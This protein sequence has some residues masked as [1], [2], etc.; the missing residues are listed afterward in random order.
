MNFMEG[1]RFSLLHGKR[2]E[3]WLVPEGC[4]QSK[5][6]LDLA[7]SVLSQL[8]HRNSE[9]FKQDRTGIAPHERPEWLIPGS[10]RDSV[11]VFV[12]GSKEGQGGKKG[13]RI[14]TWNLGK[15]DFARFLVDAQ[16]ENLCRVLIRSRRRSCGAFLGGLAYVFVNWTEYPV[17][18]KE[19]LRYVDQNTLRLNFPLQCDGPRF[20]L[21]MKTSIS[22]NEGSAEGSNTQGSWD[23]CD[24]S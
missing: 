1:M 6:R 2:K 9:L 3:T 8:Q 7:I 24:E 22:F 10:V 16:Y 21:A 13:R 18:T 4:V 19:G 5:L 12:H 14:A 15:Q 23:G 20:P 17:C 11:I